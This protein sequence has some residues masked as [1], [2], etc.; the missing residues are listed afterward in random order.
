MFKRIIILVMDSLGIGHAH[1]AERFGDQ[2]ANTLGHI[3]EVAG[4]IACPH[5]R[6]LGLEKIAD[7]EPMT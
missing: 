7:L 4:P 2:G 6:S 1:D 5:L 3:E